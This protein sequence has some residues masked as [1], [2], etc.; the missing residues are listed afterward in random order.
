MK[1]LLVILAQLERLLQSKTTFALATV[2]HVD[3]SAYR[4]PGARMLIDSEGNWWGGISGGCL[5]GDLLKKA[6]LAMLQQKIKR[7]T[8]DT[9]ED[10]PF[11]LGIGL[12]CQGLIEIMIDPIREHIQQVYEVIK[13]QIDSGKGQFALSDWSNGN[14]SMSILDQ[15]YPGWEESSQVFT[16]FLPPRT[17]IWIVGN[18]F[19]ACSLIDLC[20][21]LAWEVHWVGNTAK[22]RKDIRAKVQAIYEWDLVEGMLSSDCVVLMTHDFDRDLQFINQYIGSKAFH[23]LGILGPTKRFERLDKQ[24]VMKLVSDISTPI[25]LDL[26]AEGPDEIAVAIVAEILAVQNKRTGQRLKYRKSTIH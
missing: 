22:M 26:G 5:E 1:E 11:Q 7:I 6:Q 13:L 21:N 23:Y 12:G 2:V 19:D 16:E 17:R 20:V 3:G 18:Q 8:Y 10:D 25:G 14:F 15:A 24:L 4:R 9:R